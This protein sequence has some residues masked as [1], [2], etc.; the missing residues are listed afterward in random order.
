MHGTNAPAKPQFEGEIVIFKSPHANI[1]LLDIAR[2]NQKYGI[3]EWW[4]LND[5]TEEQI[6]QARKL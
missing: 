4:A 3:L 6:K 5:P 2:L 1:E